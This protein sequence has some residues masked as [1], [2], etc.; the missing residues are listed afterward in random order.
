M[1]AAVF[2]FA[3]KPCDLSRSR[4]TGRKDHGHG[5]RDGRTSHARTRRERNGRNS[6]SRSATAWIKK[7]RCWITTRSPHSHARKSRCVI[8]A[9]YTAYPQVIDFKKFRKIA[10]DVNAYLIVDMSHIAGL[11]AG[12]AYPSPF[13]YAECCDDDHAQNIAWSTWRDDI[14]KSKIPKIAA[15]QKEW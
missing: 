4:A 1:F 3:G 14:C 9:G 10:D 12:G 8:V 13:P 5:A 15:A 6:G 11:V 7:P 2:R